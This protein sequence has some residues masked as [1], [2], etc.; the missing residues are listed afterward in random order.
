MIKWDMLFIDGPL[1]L[2]RQ[3]K[4]V[5]LKLYT[6]RGLR[7]S[8]GRKIENFDKWLKETCYLLTDLIA[9]ALFPSIVEYLGDLVALLG[10]QWIYISKDNISIS[11]EVNL[12]FSGLVVAR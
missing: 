1:Q 3:N 2:V 8:R 6:W 12:I 5:Y 7:F 10:K 11:G 9:E 4:V